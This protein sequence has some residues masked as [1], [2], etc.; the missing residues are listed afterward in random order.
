MFS[1]AQEAVRQ[2]VQDPRNP[3]KLSE[4]RR[5][6]RAAMAHT[7]DWDEHA[8]LDMQ[9]IFLTRKLVPCVHRCPMP[10]GGVQ[11]MFEGVLA[12]PFTVHVTS[13]DRVHVTVQSCVKWRSDNPLPKELNRQGFSP[14]EWEAVWAHMSYFS[15]QWTLLT[16][17]RRVA[18]L[19]DGK[20]LQPLWQSLALPDRL[21]PIQRRQLLYYCVIRHNWSCAWLFLKA[22]TKPQAFFRACLKHNFRQQGV[23]VALLCG[24]QLGPKPVWAN[25]VYWS[26]HAM[27]NQRP[28]FTAWPGAERNAD[29]QWMLARRWSPARASWVGKAS[30]PPATLDWEPPWQF[31]WL[32]RAV[33]AAAGAAVCAGL[34]A[35]A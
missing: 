26:A 33:V 17:G 13:R 14:E 2:L 16:Q 9:E 8:M 7:Y 28:V 21:G 20:L 32:V 34:W 24:C 19:V 27:Q 23:A 35:L 10:S 29:V 3:A 30:L 4:A 25:K 11:H 18:A 5:A 12:L 31:C 1:A 6:V 22:G 15:T